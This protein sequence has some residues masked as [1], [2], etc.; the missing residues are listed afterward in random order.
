M[1]IWLLVRYLMP[2]LK[3]FKTI[4]KIL[5]KKN[6]E[7]FFI[8]ENADAAISETN[9]AANPESNQIESNKENSAPSQ[10]KKPKVDIWRKVTVGTVFE[11][12]LERY[13]IRKSERGSRFPW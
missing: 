3:F 12:A 7:L 5:K 4:T 1:Q 13:L 9:R 6:Y 11:D 2:S 8:G 10:P